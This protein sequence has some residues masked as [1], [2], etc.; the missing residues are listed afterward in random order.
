MEKPPKYEEPNI[1]VLTSTTHPL[2]KKYG[3]RDRDGY[4]T[5]VVLTKYGNEDEFKKSLFRLFRPNKRIEL[6]NAIQVYS[7]IEKIIEFFTASIKEY[8]RITN[9]ECTEMF[10]SVPCGTHT[11]ILVTTVNEDNI[12]ASTMNEERSALPGEMIE[13]RPC[14]NCGKLASLL[15]AKCKQVAYCNTKC[16]TAAW[17]THRKVCKQS[18]A[19]AVPAAAARAPSARAPS[20]V[21]SSVVA[22]VP[23]AVASSVAARVSS[24][25]SAPSAPPAEPGNETDPTLPGAAATRLPSAT[26]PPPTPNAKNNDPSAGGRRRRRRTGRTHKKRRHTRKA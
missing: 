18:E 19:C 21:A 6:K 5:I 9:R 16:Q 22:R 4:Y 10:P 15:C 3:K 26:R 8:I 24:A 25:P 11:D 20:A 7:D 12:S 13:A 14:G 1:I 17:P 2:I 23:S